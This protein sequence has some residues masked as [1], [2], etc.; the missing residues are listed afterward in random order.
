MY[1]MNDQPVLTKKSRITRHKN[2]GAILLSLVATNRNR[3]RPG[4]PGVMATQVAENP[5]KGLGCCCFF[6]VYP[7]RGTTTEFPR[8]YYTKMEDLIG[9]YQDISNRNSLATRLC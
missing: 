4:G 7:L 5:I 6:C 3:A 2:N 1:Y 9:V 8:Q